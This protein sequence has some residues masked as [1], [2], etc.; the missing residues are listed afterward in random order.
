MGAVWAATAPDR[1]Q[2]TTAILGLLFIGAG[3][4]V[5][6]LALAI[7]LGILLGDEE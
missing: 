1:H 6:G 4:G 7:I 5:L 2:M 3:I